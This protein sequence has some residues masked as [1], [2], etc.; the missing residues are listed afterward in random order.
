M[1]E[2][3][4]RTDINSLADEIR[5]THGPSALDFAVET[6]KQHLQSAA[7]K[8]CAVWLQVANRL[9]REAH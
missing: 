2:P 6:A 4:Y 9:S 3:Q 7:W 8:N 1:A 5:R